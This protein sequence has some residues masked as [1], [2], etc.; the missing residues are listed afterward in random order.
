V[1]CALFFVLSFYNSSYTCTV[2]N[3]FHIRYIGYVVLLEVV[4]CVSTRSIIVLTLVA[5]IIDPPAR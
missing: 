5:I 1:P 3:V 2:S 4:T